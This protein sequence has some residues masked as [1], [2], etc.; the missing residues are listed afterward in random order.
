MILAKQNFEGFSN[1][2]LIKGLVSIGLLMNLV[3]AIIYVGLET[4]IPGQEEMDLFLISSTVWMIM[5]Q[6]NLFD[7]KREITRKIF[8]AG[9]SLN[10]LITIIIFTIGFFWS[11]VAFIEYP[12]WGQ[13]PY[14]IYVLIT[15]FYLSYIYYD[16]NIKYIFFDSCKALIIFFT[17]GILF[18]III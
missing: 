8:R 2:Y 11:K 17:I 14:D 5:V 15:L 18:E 12:E 4:G 10:I 16:L 13:Y 7:P 9:V 3:A 6:Y 1:T